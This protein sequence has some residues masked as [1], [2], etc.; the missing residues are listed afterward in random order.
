MDQ[1]KDAIG[2]RSFSQKDPRIEFKR[3]AAR[4]YDEMI[5]VVEDKTTDVI[6]RGKMT[7]QSQGANPPGQ[8]V[9]S[10]QAADG[11]QQAPADVAG[12]TEA[13]SA[14]DATKATQP[15]LPRVVRPAA[16]VQSKKARKKPASSGQTA[17]QAIGRNEMVTLLNP[18][19]GE[20][21]EMKF[22]KAKPLIEQGW[23]LAED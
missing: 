10:A 12:G 8:R 4:L 21:E 3:E 9:N 5:S 17:V 23:R 2:F 1:V 7:Y 11:A 20:R 19:S 15:A 22:K 18:E 13:Q 14:Q 16:Q 6:M